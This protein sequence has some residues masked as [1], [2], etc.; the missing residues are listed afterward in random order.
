M[1]ATAATGGP[2]TAGAGQHFASATGNAYTSATTSVASPSVNATN[3]ATSAHHTDPVLTSVH[4]ANDAAN[5]DASQSAGE[6]AGL[7]GGLEVAFCEAEGAMNNTNWSY[8]G[9]GRGTYSAVPQVSYVG[10]G[11]GCFTPVETTTFHGW[12]FK[13]CCLAALAAL[14]LPALFYATFVMLWNVDLPWPSP[15]SFTPTPAPTWAPTPS[16]VVRTSAPYDCNVDYHKCYQCLLDRWSLSKRLWCCSHEMRGCP[17]EKPG[18]TTTS[19]WYDCNI[20]LT[21]WKIG[22]SDPKKAW[23]CKHG[24]KGCLATTSSIPYNCNEEFNHWKIAWTPEKK[25]WC[26]W[27]VNLGCPDDASTSTTPCPP[28]DCNAAFNNWQ[29]A[30]SQEKKVW[31]CQHGGRGCLPS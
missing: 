30:W 11:A 26:C 25:R 13:K 21:N 5:G 18:V 22:W 24:G 12:R 19:E 15:W 20:G 31:C 9:D 7:C 29:A 3:T 28:H 8:V 16:P 23:C 1:G 17:T 14:L 2:P 4:A 27:H 6:C 10:Q